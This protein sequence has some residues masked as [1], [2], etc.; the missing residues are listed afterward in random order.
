VVE[1][2]Y[3]AAREQVTEGVELVSIVPDA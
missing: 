3:Y 2:V 1:A